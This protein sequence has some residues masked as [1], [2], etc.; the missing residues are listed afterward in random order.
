MHGRMLQPWMGSAG[1][2]IGSAGLSMDLFFILLT[3]AGIK[4]LRKKSD[5]L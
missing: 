3:E 1:P 2:W 4:P 5:L